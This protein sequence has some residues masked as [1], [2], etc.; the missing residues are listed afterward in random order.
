VEGVEVAA[1]G[2]ESR[3]EMKR[4]RA[5]NMLAILNGVLVVLSLEGR[6]SGKRWF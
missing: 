1:L 4:L 5:P 3:R 2:S 6:N